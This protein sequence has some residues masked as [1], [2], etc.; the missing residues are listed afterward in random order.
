VADFPH[1]SYERAEGELQ[2]LTSQLPVLGVTPIEVAPQPNALL[3][4]LSNGQFDVLHVAGH[5]ESAIQQIEEAA[6]ILG[7]R[8]TPDGIRPVTVKPGTVEG[9]ADLNERRPLIFLNACETGRQGPKL[10]DFGGWPQ[11]FIRSGAGAYVGTSWAVRERPAIA[12]AQG[13]YESL[14]KGSTL[15]EASQHARTQA[16]A[17]GDASWLAFTVYGAPSAR[18]VLAPVV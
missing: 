17:I 1:N 7:D 13:F 2:F 6:L 12:F 11:A 10:T 9:V 16:K 8:R 15:A 14:L 5:A 3:D 4:L 18:F